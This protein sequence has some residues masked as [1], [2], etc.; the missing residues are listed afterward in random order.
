M[1]RVISLW[2]HCNISFISQLSLSHEFVTQPCLCLGFEYRLAG[3]LNIVNQR[4][5]RTQIVSHLTD[6]FYFLRDKYNT[7]L[8]SLQWWVLEYQICILSDHGAIRPSLL[9]SPNAIVHGAQCVDA[10]KEAILPGRLAC[11]IT[12]LLPCNVLPPAGCHIING[13]LVHRHMTCL[14]YHLLW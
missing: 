4:Y 6:Q 8:S 1:S 2:C 9:C 3:G 10:I 7:M 13:S 11:N 5:C 12:M 14:F